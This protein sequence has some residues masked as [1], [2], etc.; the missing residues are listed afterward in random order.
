MPRASE[1][2]QRPHQPGNAKNQLIC[3]PKPSNPK[4]N[5][6]WKFEKQNGQIEKTNA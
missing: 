3:V 4:T 1:G 6:D 5:K 2:Y